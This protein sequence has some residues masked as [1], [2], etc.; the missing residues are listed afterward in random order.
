MTNR[1]LLE[2]TVQDCGAVYRAG[3]VRQVAWVESSR[4]AVDSVVIGDQ[5][6]QVIEDQQS[7]TTA[8]FGACT[9]E[10]L[11]ESGRAFVDDLE[12]QAGDLVLG[13]VKAASVEGICEAVE[14]DVGEG[15]IG[16]RAQQ[17]VRDVASCV[18]SL[19]RVGVVSL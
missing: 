13:I 7:Q 11:G 4:L 5:L 3:K 1:T 15:Q 14:F 9:G 19:S 2:N 10:D 18:A 17:T 12:R 6:S 16:D 8:A